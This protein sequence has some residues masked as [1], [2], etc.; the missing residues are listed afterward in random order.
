MRTV[1]VAAHV[2]SKWSYDASWSLEE[3]ARAF[4][5]RRYDAVLLSEH[6]RGFTPQRWQDYQRA[7]LE[8]STDRIALVPGIEYEDGEN[9]VHIPVWGVDI[10]FLGEGRPTLDTLRAAE[11]EQAVAVF[12]HPWRR[13]AV[14]RYLPDWAPY[15][16]AVEVWNRRYDG[17]APNRRGTDFARRESL[18]PF[19]SLDFHT[20][21]Q[22]FPLAMSMEIEG[23]TSSATLVD[24]IRTG[25]CRPEVL[26]MSA[27]RFTQGLEGATAQ[28]LE[29]ARRGVA[30]RV[31]RWQAIRGKWGPG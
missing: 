19:V 3:I 10:P 25:R 26:G 30:R 29:A 12:A 6:D 1:R 22:F 27:L 18:A 11:G 17:I 16:S 31:R 5:R 9:V 28:A 4:C 8:A 20:R 2:H 15:L 21:R 23:A 24:A 13:E 14:S 7:C